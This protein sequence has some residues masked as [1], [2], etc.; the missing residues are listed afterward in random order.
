MDPRSLGPAAQAMILR[1]RG[2]ATERQ[3]TGTSRDTQTRGGRNFACVMW[4]SRGKSFGLLQYICPRHH[5]QH[6]TITNKIM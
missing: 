6:G 2:F 1:G 5:K 4:A 3:H